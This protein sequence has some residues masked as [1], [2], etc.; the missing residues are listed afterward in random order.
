MDF[1][2]AATK[3][4]YIKNKIEDT[5]V[6]LEIANPLICN[7]YYTDQQH[8]RVVASD[9][10]TSEILWIM[11]C[12]FLENIFLSH[13]FIINCCSTKQEQI[14][15]GRRKYLKVLFS[16][17]KHQHEKMINSSSILQFLRKY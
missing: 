11:N 9:A 10:A 13:F 1:H 8:C 7:E 6:D 2:A 15:S 12:L 14:N 16:E 17:L 5:E 3:Y 4:F